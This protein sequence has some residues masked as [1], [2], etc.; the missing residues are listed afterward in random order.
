[1]RE[2]VKGRRQVLALRQGVAV[3]STGSMLDVEA[4]DDEIPLL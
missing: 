2:V 1:M 4:Y 3:D